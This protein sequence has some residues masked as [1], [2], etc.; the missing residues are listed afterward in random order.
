M[1]LHRRIAV[2][3]FTS[4]IA[5]ALQIVLSLLLLPIMFRHLSDEAIGMWYL[6]GSATLFLGLLDFGFGPTLTRRIAFAK[7][8]SGGHVDV[9]LNAESR[10]KL[11]D[12]FFTGKVVFRCLAL[13]ILLLAGGVG[14]ILLR[15][16]PLN[17]LTEGEVLGAWALFCLSYS[18]NAW[19]GL[20][21]TL[22]S[23]LG[24]V[25][26]A[27][28]ITIIMQVVAALAKIIAVSRGGSLLSLATIDC[29]TAIAT[30]QLLRAYLLWKETDV[31]TLTGRW[32]TIDFHSILTPALKYWITTLGAF[33]ILKTDE[34]FIIYFLNAAAIAD[35]KAAYVVIN[36]LSN[37]ALTFALVSV[38]FYSQLWQAG[39]LATLQ[40]VLMRNLAVTLGVMLSGV[41]AVI[42]A[43]PCLF[44]IWL[45]PGRFVGFPIL[46]AFSTMLFLETQHCTFASAARSTEDEVYALWALGAGLLNLVFTW[47]LG[48]R[49]GLLGIALGT[50]F[51]Q[52]V[53]NNWYCVYHGLERLQIPFST[54]ATRILVPLAGLALATALPLL[55]VVRYL[56][57][58]P[59][60]PADWLQLMVVT[61]WSGLILLLFLWC[62]ALNSDERFRLTM[63]I[64]SL[65]PFAWLRRRP[66]R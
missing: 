21:L 3:V 61:A 38:P 53:T 24:Y 18:I 59:F 47:F 46:F 54:Y 5:R 55:I 7:G 48:Q 9:E 65:L 22:L 58:L 23:G 44:N 20:W 36:C 62:V 13:V 33:L 27:N 31:L 29:V 60:P 63:K 45:G 16:V 26:S 50:L 34:I 2:G 35:Y 11:G 6:L 4:Y 32:S 28:L 56:P 19:G 40:S 57:A 12:L 43:S 37:L 42:L 66:S 25:G 30:R 8:I 1:G 39:D 15:R 64:K 10:E 14:T 52:L 17:H 41:T 49:Y 51:A